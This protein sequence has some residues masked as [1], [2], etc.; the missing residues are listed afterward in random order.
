LDTLINPG[1]QVRATHVHGITDEMISD[2]PQFRDI[3]HH[4]SSI[5]DGTVIAAHNASFDLGFLREEFRR[6]G[7][8][9]P[10]ITPVCTLVMAR[11]YLKSLPSKSLE[12]CRDFLGLSEKGAHNALAD[13]WSAASLLKYFIEEF[14]PQFNVK[15]FH[16]ALPDESGGLFDTTPTFKSR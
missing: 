4:L 3:V 7:T 1:V 11:N 9:L 8:S 13:A 15:P 14:N 10:F 5:L 6:A 2:A 12:S 16:S